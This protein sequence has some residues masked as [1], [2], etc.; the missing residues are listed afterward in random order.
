MMPQP[1]SQVAAYAQLAC[2]LEVSAPKPGNVSPARRFRDAAYSDFLASAVA[3]GPAFAAAGAE[4]LGKTILAA[5]EA[6]QRWTKANTNLGLVLLFAPLARAALIPGGDLGSRLERVLSEATVA[7]AGDVYAAIRLV[8][9]GGLGT[10]AEQDV[11]EAPSVTLLDAM[12]L[13]RDRDAIAREYVTCFATTFGVAAPALRRARRDGLS[14][15]DAIVETYLTLLAAEPDSLILRKAGAAA[16]DV[17]ARA[18]AVLD[19][20]GLR[21]HAGRHLLA[22]LDRDLGDPANRLNPGSTA[23]LTGAAIFVALLEGGW[24]AAA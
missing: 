22:I 15:S 21:Q 8:N 3:I 24:C 17:Q 4:P 10:V 18:R 14:W 1:G 5:V 2:L 12:A 23:D 13:A 16:Q 7:D 11:R 19:S 20:G 9:P 6:T